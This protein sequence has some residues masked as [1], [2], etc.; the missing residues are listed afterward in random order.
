MPRSREALYAFAIAAMANIGLFLAVYMPLNARTA[1][2]DP[3][4]LFLSWEQSIPFVEWMIVPYLSFN[5]LFLI[6]LF[7]L[8]TRA[9]ARLGLAFACTTLAAGL[10]FF[11]FP[12]ELGYPRV[13]PS[14]WTAPLYR[15]LFSVDGPGNLVPSLHAA[16][17]MV[18]FLSGFSALPSKRSRALLS[19]W[20]AL[21]LA[22]TVLTHQHHLLD[23]VFGILLGCGAHFMITRR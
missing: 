8:S 3:L 18:F 20:V 19:A 11:F 17:T 7:V 23:L 12:A 1:G 6:P 15:G 2:H 13:I 16:Y 21:I 14:D 9:L 22:S 10:F 4:R 5:L